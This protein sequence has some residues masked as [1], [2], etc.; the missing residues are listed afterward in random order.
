MEV[1]VEVLHEGCCQRGVLS[2]SSG[3]WLHAKRPA[4]TCEG[5]SG[6]LLGSVVV[7]GV[8]LSLCN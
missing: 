3:I 4:S 2:S 8:I 1:C 5:G 7:V 6:D